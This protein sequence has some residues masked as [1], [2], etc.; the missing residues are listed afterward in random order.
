MGTM[1]RNL[2]LLAACC[3]TLLLAKAP[4]RAVQVVTTAQ[5]DYTGGTI[6]IDTVYGQVNVEGWDQP[7]VRITVT[8]T[9]FRH[10]TPREQEEG[11]A[12]LNRI[13]VT[14]KP[15]GKG[16]VAIDTRF[17]GRNRVMRMIHG[18]GD[19]TLDYRI[20]VPRNAKLAIRQGVGDVTVHGVAGDVDAVARSGDIVVQVAGPEQYAIDAQCR[21][22]TIYSDFDGTQRSPYLVGQKLEGGSGHTLHLRVG[23]GGISI[24]R[25]PEPVLTAEAPSR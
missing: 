7:G 13:Q 18:L 3:G 15:D 23:V 11:K 9:A 17:P 2:A 25:I 10:D 16:G 14:T 8:R 5:S 22:G 24:Q 6:R 4:E 20:Q 12:Y 1:F 19:F 21:L